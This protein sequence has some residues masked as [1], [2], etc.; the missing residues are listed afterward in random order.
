MS[1]N[2]IVIFAPRWHDRKL[3]VADW[4][5]GEKNMIEVTAR[6]KNG[7]L[8]FPRKFFGLGADLKKYPLE[9]IPTKNGQTAKMRVIPI[10]DLETVETHHVGEDRLFGEN[11]E[12]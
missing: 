9:D 10:D 12:N 11:D 6:N 8:H 1:V 3:L 4:K 2:H 5:I 7:D